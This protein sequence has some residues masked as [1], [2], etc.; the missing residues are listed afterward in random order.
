[1]FPSKRFQECKAVAFGF[2]DIYELRHTTSDCFRGLLST[3][4]SLSHTYRVT[5]EASSQGSLWQNPPN[6]Q[7]VDEAYMKG[8]IGRRAKGPIIETKD[9]DSYWLVQ[10]CYHLPYLVLKSLHRIRTVHCKY[11]SVRIDVQRRKPC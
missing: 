2:R 1:M 7:R 5:C 4:K 6:A 11:V 9:D 3:I 10:S 8:G